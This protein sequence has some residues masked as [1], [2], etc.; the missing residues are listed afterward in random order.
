MNNEL[1]KTIEQYVK[2]ATK[3]RGLCIKY[4]TAT[5]KQNNGN[6]DWEDIELPEYV[7]VPYDGGNHPEYASNV[8]STVYGVFFDKEKNICLKTEDCDRYY[9]DDVTTDGFVDLVNFLDTYTKEIGIKC[10]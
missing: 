3:L 6:I 5:L 9:I 7:S 1:H 10:D 4:L 2:T 8:F